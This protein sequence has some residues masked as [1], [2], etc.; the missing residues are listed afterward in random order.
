MQDGHVLGER[1]QALRG[2]GMNS[3]ALAAKLRLQ[4][5]VEWAV[6]DERRYISAAPND[7]YYGP[8]QVAITPAVGQWYLRK[9]DAA[10]ASST[11]TVVSSI[12][13][14][15]A[16][17][18][19]TGSASV[20]VAVLD[21]GVLFD[22]PDLGRAASGGKLWPGYDFVS[23]GTGIATNDGNGIDPDASDPGDYTTSTSCGPGTVVDSSS[24]HGTQTAGLVGAATDN[25]TGIASLGRNTMVLP[26][27]VLGPCGGTDSDIIAAMY[28]AAGINLPG[29]AT[30][31]ATY[32]GISANLHPAKVISMSLGAP[33]ACPPS[34]NEVFAALA[35]AQVTVVVAAGNNSTGGIAVEAPANCSGAIA[36][37]GLRNVGTKVGFSDLGP[38]VAIAA[39]GGNCVNSSGACLY[40]MMSTTNTGT[41]TPLLNTYSDSKNYALGTSFSAPLVAGTIALMLAI[42]PTLKA[43]KILSVLKSTARPF[44]KAGA[45]S[46]TAAACRPPSATG[47]DECYCTT[48]TC[49]AGML[50]AGAAVAAVVALVAPPT[51]AITVSNS[52]PTAGQSVTLSASSATANGGR[53]IAG[54]HWQIT[55][56]GSFAAFSGASNGASATLLTSA[57]GSVVVSLTVTDSAGAS[58]SASSTLSV[59]AAS[60]TPSTPAATGGSSSGG[61]G[62]AMSAAWVYGLGLAAGALYRTRRR[63]ACRP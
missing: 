44:P 3:S 7:P 10:L 45:L 61:G 17:A 38:E 6:V 4:D 33:T 21:T 48:S 55:S 35:A 62:G 20:T 49:G 60:A 59:Q 56:G 18:L 53:S 52:A 36:V 14:E 63:A 11:S 54:Y 57:A 29:T 16:W 42:D 30:N 34:Y 26:V 13:S 41:T 37:A 51:T 40:P 25:A 15:A 28:W 5:D 24:W 58:G 46:A 39:P 50:D 1:M 31:Y 9:P 23:G 27:R 43:D 47:Q 22:H 2:Q 32:A 19:T 12:D 8:N